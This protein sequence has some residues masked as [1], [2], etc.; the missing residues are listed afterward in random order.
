MSIVV[1]WLIV[2]PLSV[3]LGLLFHW[4]RIP[5]GWILAA[6]LVSGAMALLSGRELPI[7]SR[8]Y[9]FS[10]G[11]I[12]ILA[13]VPLVSVPPREVLSLLPAGVFVATVTLGIGVAG[14]LLLARSQPAIGRETG[15][16]SM[17]A[18]AASMM[19]AIATEVGAD[20]R[21][22]ALGQYLRLLVVSITLPMVAGVLPMPGSTSVD[23]ATPVTQDSWLMVAL[24]LLVSLI[25]QPIARAL[26]IPVPGMLGPLLLTVLISTFLPEGYTMRPPEVLTVLSFLAVGWVCGGMLSVPALTV[27]ARQLPATIAF[28][29]V[30]MAACALSALPLTYWLDVTYFE[31]YLATS[32]GA[33]E[34]VLALGSEGGAGPEVVVIQMI[35]LMGVLTVVGFLP[36]M[37]G[38]AGGA[39]GSGTKDAG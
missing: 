28:I 13:A 6:I 39:G 30:V 24:I 33:L 36:R 29:V 7:N 26:R 20:P 3:A 27:F 31:A 1:R 32:P 2:A 4:W 37:L 19:P 10:R 25:G 11:I 22:V 21:Y 9:Q 17:L 38:G 18:G 35:R 23:T 15:V 12:G 34:T 5:A 14:G 8:F 16:L